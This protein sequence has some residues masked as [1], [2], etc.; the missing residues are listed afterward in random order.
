MEKLPPEPPFILA[1][2]HASHLDAPVLA[3]ILPLR[4]RDRVSPL[5]A[6]DLFFATK[7]RAA[8]S[9]MILDVY[10]PVGGGTT[11][12]APR[13]KSFGA[14]CSKINVSILYSRKAHGR[15]TAR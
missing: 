5:A 11:P 6:G 15:G 2:N 8:F 14:A 3:S 12:G 10:L 4:W 13:C 9:G 1:A 7:Y